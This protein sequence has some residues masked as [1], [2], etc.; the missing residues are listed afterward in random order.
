[1]NADVLKR[2][3]QNILVNTDLF[4]NYTTACFIP[5]EN[6]EDLVKGLLQVVT[7]IR[8]SK[9]VQVRTDLALALKALANK[10]NEELDKSVS[11]IIQ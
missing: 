11:L 7:P 6:K 5:S 4:S 3:N 2:A 9:S 10:T 8:H 1:M